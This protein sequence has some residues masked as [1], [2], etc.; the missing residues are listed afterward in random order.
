MTAH[1]TTGTVAG[2]MLERLRT[3]SQPGQ[4][5]DDHVVAVA[6]E[7]GGMRGVVSAGMLVALEQVGLSSA[8]DLVVGTSAGAISGAFFA[9]GQAVEGSALFHTALLSDAFLD[10][11]RLIRRE[12]ALDLDHLIDDAAAARGLDL[13]VLAA[14][15]IPLY[16]TVSPVEPDNPTRF[17]RVAGDPS[18]MAAILKASASLPVIAGGS[19]MVDGEHYVDGGLHEQVP[20]RTAA[21][22]GATHV[23]VLPSRPVVAQVDLDSLSFVERLAVLPVV[24]RFHGDYVASLV[25]ELPRRSTYAAWNLRAV[26]D[27][28][29]TPVRFGMEGPWPSEV[30]AAI[31]LEPGDE[32]DAPVGPAKREW[33]HGQGPPR[34]DI[35]ELDRDIALPRR[36]ERSRPLLVDALIDGAEAV[37]RHFEFADVAVEQRVVLTHPEVLVKKYRSEVLA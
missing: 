26:A 25:A 28:L 3:G 8:I 14:G 11:S 17:F 16:A 12:A 18:R 19:R 32:V 23:L 5:A 20:W 36:L 1:D 30:E 34:F 10:R 15:K 35:V 27:G 4:R 31:D 9:T 21:A 37:V 33:V 13:T 2:I 22:L 6:I 29:A 7:G 24:R